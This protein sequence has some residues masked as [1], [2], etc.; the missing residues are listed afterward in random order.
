MSYL[1]VFLE[2]VETLMVVIELLGLIS[3]SE[4]RDKI[5]GA[6]AGIRVAL[7]LRNGSFA[8]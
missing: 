3:H 4:I 8:V 6:C 5:F 2:C 7:G 1:E